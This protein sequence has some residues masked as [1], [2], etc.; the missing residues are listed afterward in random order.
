VDKED[1]LKKQVTKSKLSPSARKFFKENPKVYNILRESENLNQARNGLLQM[2]F[3]VERRIRMLEL[4]YHPLFNVMATDAIYVL[5]TIFA[6]RSEMLTGMSSLR[7]LRDAAKGRAGNVSDGFF[8]EFRHLFFA[9]RGNARVY[10]ETVQKMDKGLKGRK[11]AR[12]RSRELDLL[13]ERSRRYLAR[14]HTG[15]EKKIISRRHRNAGRIMKYYGATEKDWKNYRWHFKN[16]IKDADTVKALVKIRDEDYESIK[17]AENNRIPFGI[18]PYYLS[19]FDNEKPRYDLAIRAQVL[20]PRDYVDHMATCKNRKTDLDFMGELDTSPIDLITRRYPNILI[21]KP[22]NA[23]PQVCTYCQRNWEIDEVMAP[24]ATAPKEKLN[25][26]ISW[27]AEDDAITEVLITGGD[28]FVLSDDDLDKLLGKISRIKHV[29]NIRLGTRTLITVPFRV[30]KNLINILKKYNIPGKSRIC[31]VTHAENAY[32]ITPDVVEACA[33]IRNAGISIYN[34]MVFTLPNSRRF[35]AGKLRETL[36]L[37]G[38]DPYYTFN[39]KGH[40][41]MNMLRVPIARLL[42]EQK[43][44]SRLLPGITRTD[45]AVFNVPRLGKN[46]LRARQDHNI[47]MITPSGERIYIFHPWE[48]NIAV[49]DPYIMEDVPIMEYL[50]ALE[51]I[52]EDRKEYESIWYYY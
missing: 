40:Q 14:Y 9:V 26:A 45:E 11:A 41:E 28:P 35:E 10:G 13:A 20:P 15:L 42:Q 49:K 43:E 1:V 22:Y 51:S 8:E 23:C 48:K 31:M 7:V 21:L 44:E 32:E 52:G 30:T 27:I 16:V 18:T 19:L 12:A 34:Q 6:K 39:T 29:N 47:L 46:H 24:G 38:I 3:D 4:S 37:V 33:K 2:I 36:R 17:K 25:K 5:R 50:D